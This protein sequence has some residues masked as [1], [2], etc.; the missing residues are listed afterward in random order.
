MQAEMDAFI[1]TMLSLMSIMTLALIIW[2]IS[3]LAENIGEMVSH[4]KRRRDR[5]KML[6][7]LD[8]ACMVR[9]GR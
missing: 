4:A 7:T 3:M 2:G 6:K 8:S 5:K 9:L 1:I